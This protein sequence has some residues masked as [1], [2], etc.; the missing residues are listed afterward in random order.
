MMIKKSLAA[1]LTATMLMMEWSTI[2]WVSDGTNKHTGQ[3]TTH[4]LP[5][6]DAGVLNHL[7]LAQM[8]E[9]DISRVDP[10]AL[11]NISE[12]SIDQALPQIDKIEQYLSQICNPY[13]FMSGDTPVRVRFIHSDKPLSQSLRSYF[14]RL[15]ST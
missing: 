7:E 11:V 6:R 10:A 13:C 3:A 8:R 9:A 1:L 15:K 2:A 12:V 4:I 14:S 5:R